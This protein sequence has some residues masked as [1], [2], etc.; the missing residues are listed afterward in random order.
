MFV[1]VKAEVNFKFKVKLMF[2]LSLSEKAYYLKL[3]RV[4][5]NK[6]QNGHGGNNN[7][8]NHFW[9]PKWQKG[10]EPPH[11]WAEPK[12]NYLFNQLN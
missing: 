3:D 7:Y 6:E 8:Y 2:K 12:F 11:S 9:G 5:F 4:K 1:K 10:F